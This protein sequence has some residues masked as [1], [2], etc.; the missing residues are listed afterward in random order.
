[1]KNALQSELFADNPLVT[2]DPNI[3][4]YAGAPLVNPEGYKLGTL[5]VIDTE[6]KQLNEKQKETLQILSRFVINQFELRR[7]KQELERSRDIYLNLV[8]D[9]GDI[10]YT[11]DLEGNFNYIS[12]AVSKI[13]GYRPEEL[14]G[15]HFTELV[16]ED[17]KKRTQLYYIRQFRDKMPKTT[18]EFPMI[19]SSGEQRWVEQTV[20]LLFKDGEPA[21]FQ[22]IVRD[23]SERKEAEEKLAEAN[24]LFT[25]IFHTSPVAMSLGAL[26]PNRFVEVNQSFVSF[27]GYSQEE[28]IGKNSAEVGLMG[29]AERDEVSALFAKQG[30]LRNLE[31][32]MF[33]KAGEEKYALI[34]TEIIEMGGKNFIL[35][36]YY[37]ITKRKKYEIELFEAKNLFTKIFDT[38]PVAMSLGSLKPYKYIEVNESFS[39]LTGYTQDELKSLDFEKRGLV[40]GEERAKMLSA[41]AQEGSL[42]NLEV[43]ITVQNGEKRYILLSTELIDIGGQ[44]LALSV[45]H[46]ITERKLLEEQLVI[47][48]EQAEDSARAKEQFLANMSHEI[49]TPINGVVGFTELLMNTKLNKDQKEF[50]HAV[51]ASGK[52]LLSVVNNILDYSKIDAGMMDIEEIPLSIRSIFSSLAILFSQRAK[53]KKIKLSFS[54]ARVIPEIVIGDPA[55]LTQ[56]FTNLVGNALKFTEKG[57]ITATASLVKKD[58]EHVRVK[59][60]VKDTGIGIPRSKRASI[61]ERFNQ[62]SNDTNRKYGGTGLGLSI[63]KKLVELQHGNISVKSTPGKGSAF[64]FTIV[65]KTAQEQVKLAAKTTKTLKPTGKAVKLHVLL[66]EDNEMN[67]KLAMRVLGNFGYTSEIAGNGKIAV[68]KLKKNT[69]DL[70]IMDMQMPVMDGYEATTIIRNKLRSDVP[71]IAMTAHAMSS[72]KEKCLRLGMNDYISKPFRPSDLLTIIQKITGERNDA[73]KPVKAI[74]AK[75]AAVKKTKYLNLSEL[76]KISGNDRDFIYDMLMLF[77]TEFPKDLER[78]EESLEKKNYEVIKKVTHKLKSSV[79]LVGLGQS[80]GKMLAEME[81]LADAKK[82]LDKLKIMFTDLNKVLK[83]ALAEAAIEIKK[84][85]K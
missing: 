40:S 58:K 63:V 21:G 16:A 1:M 64:E 80:A 3:R 68:D 37:D 57:S 36:V 74:K 66:V 11:C 47:A 45:Y 84:Y 61:F 33:T 13:S 17:W 81:H 52:N 41:F 34:S 79:S 46:D 55:R 20:V 29:N 4:F 14:A 42:R 39:K 83:P 25:R 71:I 10:I 69:Y 49:R 72:E 62:G 53:E 51:D 82:G 22:G 19:T 67:Q 65:Y 5:C 6:P 15:K 8:E 85:G 2:G 70:V 32:K 26:N 75:A 43:K 7:T 9:A 48:K 77:M 60:V 54:A 27:T 56:I 23:I 59:F 76:K 50:V 24:Q 35:N 18:M 30:F 44:G 28:M 73:E 38:S 31:I 78:I 12:P